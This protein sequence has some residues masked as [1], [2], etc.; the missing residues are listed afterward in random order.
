[1]AVVTTTGSVGGA[2]VSVIQNFP[3][4]FGISPA[5]FLSFVET[6]EI[7]WAVIASNKDEFVTTSFV[8]SKHA[9]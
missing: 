1:M 7:V 5:Y 9:R 3:K 8:G 6:L 2:Y 4:G